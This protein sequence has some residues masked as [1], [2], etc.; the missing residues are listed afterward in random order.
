MKSARKYKFKN[1][2]N[3]ILVMIL[4]WV[5]ISS[6]IQRFKCSEMTETQLFIHIPESFILNWKYCN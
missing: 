3:I 2:F 1:I 4:L 6:I 5:A